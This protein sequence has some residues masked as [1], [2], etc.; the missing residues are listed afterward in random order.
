L[1]DIEDASLLI[2][3]EVVSEVVPK[4]SADAPSSFCSSGWSF[5]RPF[6]KQNALVDISAKIPASRQKT[7]LY[8]G[9]PLALLY[10]EEPIE[11]TSGLQRL[12][13]SQIDVSCSRFILVTR[14]I[15][16]LGHKNQHNTGQRI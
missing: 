5:V 14:L 11:A 12:Q 6:A 13:N 7:P 2:V 3:L 10:L 16:D 15:S 4:S 1:T 8:F 9:S